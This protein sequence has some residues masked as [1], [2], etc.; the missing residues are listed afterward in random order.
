MTPS[1][2]L[3][4][5]LPKFSYAERQ[6]AF[7][8]VVALHSGYFVARQCDQFVGTGPGGPRRRFLLQVA[9]KGHVRKLPSCD[10]TI[11]YHLCVRRFYAALGIENSAAA[12]RTS[13]SASRP[14]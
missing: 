9:A 2:A 8:R 10:R 5:R 14:G 12:G 3:S 11:I 13:R 1:A 7:L 4:G 6:A